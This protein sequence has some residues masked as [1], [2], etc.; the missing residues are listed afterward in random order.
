[1]KLETSQT[2]TQSSKVDFFIETYSKFLPREKLFS[3]RES[4]LQLPDDKVSSLSSSLEFKKPFAVFWLDFFL[5]GFGV[6][7]FY[8]GD[9]LK[10]VAMLSL[11]LLS[12]LLIFL[13]PFIG[14]AGLSL[15]FGIVPLVV[16][17]L[18]V[19]WSIYLLLWLQQENPTIKN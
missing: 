12:V 11:L 9:I 17:C 14:F 2:G 6:A 13:V 1:M 7:R 18:F 3:I 16:W 19:G 8:I 4:L 10:G 5:G 15:V